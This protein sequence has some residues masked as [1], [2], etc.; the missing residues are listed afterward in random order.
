MPAVNSAQHIPK[1][2]ICNFPLIL[3]GVETAKIHLFSH[4]SISNSCIKQIDAFEIQTLLLWIIWEGTEA[5]YYCS[6]FKFSFVSS[7]CWFLHLIPGNQKW[8]LGAAVGLHCHYLGPLGTRPTI[9]KLSSA[10]QVDSRI[11]LWPDAWWT[12][13]LEGDQKL[14]AVWVWLWSPE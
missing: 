3:A 1:C 5:V 4:A 12:C 14:R 8:C 2:V 6:I 11:T 13:A 7:T 9:G 10:Q